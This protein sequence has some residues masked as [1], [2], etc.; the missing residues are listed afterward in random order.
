MNVNVTHHYQN[1][2][3]KIFVICDSLKYILCK[4]ICVLTLD[5]WSF[6]YLYERAQSSNFKLFPV[7]YWTQL[8]AGFLTL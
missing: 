2:F 7:I 6:D 1:H 3:L 5:F 4:C 8:T